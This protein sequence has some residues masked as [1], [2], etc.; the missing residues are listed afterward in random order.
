MVLIHEAYTYEGIPR[1]PPAFQDF[2]PNTGLYEHSEATQMGLFN[3]QGYSMV[4]Y[5]K[6]LDQI[7]LLYPCEEIYR[8]V[9]KFILTDVFLSYEKYILR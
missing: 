4:F 1:R 2:R 7:T 6:L 8:N 9:D 3:G 5:S